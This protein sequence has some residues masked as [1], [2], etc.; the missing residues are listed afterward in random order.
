MHD[1][2]VTGPYLTSLVLAWVTIGLFF[3]RPALATEAHLAATARQYAES[4]MAAAFD[5][6]EDHYTPD[7]RA[8]LS[9]SASSELRDALIARNGAIARIGDAWFEDR[10]QTYTRYRVALFFENGPLDMRVVFD[11]QGRIAGMFFVEHSEPPPSAD[12]TVRETNVVVGSTETGLPGLL[13]L[14]EGAGPF[15]AVILIHGSGPS[16]R[17]ETIG[18]NKPFRDLAWGLAERGIAS[19]RYDKRSFAR[20]DDLTAVG[21]R[22]TV[23]EEVIDDAL[24][25]LALLRGRPEIEHAAIFIVGHSLCGTLAPRIAEFEPSPAGVVVLA[26]MTR[27]LP[28]KMLEQTEY[29]VSLDG[30]VTPAEHQRVTEIEAAVAAIRKGLSEEPIAGGYYLGAPLAYYR[31]LEDYDA[32]AKLASLDLPC[33]V[34]QGARDYQVTLDDFALWRDSL[35]GTGK[36]CLRVHDDLDHLF[37]PGTGLS[38]PSDYDVYGVV[39]PAIIDCIARWIHTQVCCSE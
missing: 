9:P 6:V 14:P 10:I 34:L 27:P 4:F 2:S 36:A 5:D 39:D 13:A 17:D 23:K 8:A 21:D 3:P 7:M 24:A 11:T 28:E 35:S 38:G 20:P 19:L 32:P 30:V 16:D 25:G 15:P 26:G 37:R 12:S 29:I 1:R 33:L 22:L 31:D 18:P